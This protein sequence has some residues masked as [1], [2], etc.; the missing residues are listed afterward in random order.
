MESFRGFYLCNSS[1]SSYNA[2]PPQAYNQYAMPWTPSPTRRYP[3]LKQS[4]PPACTNTR[5]EE[6]EAASCRQ[7]QA[8]RR[9][10]RL[11]PQRSESPIHNPSPKPAQLTNIYHRLH[12]PH[13]PRPNAKHLLPP[14]QSR[15]RN[16]R[17][18][19][20]HKPKRHPR[21]TRFQLRQ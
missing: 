2:K 20:H 4:L 3:S 13:R 6:A 16:R 9:H 1:E 14:A 10:S 5:E 18:T 19:T 11:W 7:S 17:T 8:A 21:R 12:H 15:I